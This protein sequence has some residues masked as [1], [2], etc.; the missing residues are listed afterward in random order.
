[1][2][3]VEHT[4]IVLVNVASPMIAQ[5]MI[6][7]RQRAGIIGIAVAIQDVQPFPS[8]GMKEM[9]PIW[10]FRRC[11]ICCRRTKTAERNNCYE[12]T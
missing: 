9:K 6:D 1:M 11:S 10:D 4:R 12:T 3:Q 8:V 7:S 2:E 5:V